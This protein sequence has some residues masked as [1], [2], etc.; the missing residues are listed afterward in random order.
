MPATEVDLS[1]HR[2]F[3][4]CNERFHRGILILASVCGR[5]GF[6]MSKHLGRVTAQGIKSGVVS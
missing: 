6:E 4:L 1:D 2:T 5:L 3:T